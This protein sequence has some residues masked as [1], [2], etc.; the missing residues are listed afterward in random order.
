VRA[1]GDE[2][3]ESRAGFGDGIGGG[4]ADGVEAVRLRLLDDTEFQFCAIG[5]KS[6]SP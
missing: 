5:Q 4:D 3:V 2:V 6:R 1:G